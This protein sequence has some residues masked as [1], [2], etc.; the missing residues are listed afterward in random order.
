[1]T[2]NLTRDHR[3]IAW[4]KDRG[5]Y[6]LIDRKGPGGWGNPF[7][8]DED[9]GGDGDGDRATVIA[10]YGVYLGLKPSL[11]RRLDELRGKVLGCHCYPLAC[12]GDVLIEYL[13]R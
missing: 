13:A 9:L 5:L 6:V 10:S 12:H 8:L 4:A 11:L 1:V 3:L 2:A 7:Y